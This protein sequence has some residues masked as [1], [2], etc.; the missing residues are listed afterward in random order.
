MRILAIVPEAFGG[1][2]GIAVYNRDLLTALADS[3]LCE[4]VTVL[5]RLIRHTPVMPLPHRIE[6]REG[7]A[8]SIVRYA[9]ELARVLAKRERYD[10]VLC[11]HINLLPFA[12]IARRVLRAKQVLLIYGIDAWSPTGRGI[13]DRLVGSTDLVISISQFTKRRFLSWSTVHDSQVHLLPNAVH[14][15]EYGIGEKPNYLEERY[16]LGGQK[17]L[18]TLARLQQNERQKGLDEMLEVFPEL[19]AEERNLSYLI[20]G[21]GDDRQR[22]ERKAASLGL[23]GYV[24]FAGRV[25]EAEKAD[26]YRLADALVMPGRQEG[27]GFVFV[28]AMASGIPVVASSVDGSREA[29]LDG[30]IGEIADPDDR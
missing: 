17:V 12:E 16:G 11:G 19:L 26:Y 18:M 22:L 5:P 20:A 29:V 4:K 10:V 13:T 14:M 6:L 30:E 2:G 24:V 9:C 25:P 23:N 3:Q 27:C 28:E 21:D 1:F 15:E 8:N 7:A